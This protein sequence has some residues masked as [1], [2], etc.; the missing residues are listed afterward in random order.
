MMHLC[1]I[2][3]APLEIRFIDQHRQA[4]S[5]ARHIRIRQL[6]RVE[7]GADYALAGGGFLNLSDQGELPLPG[8]MFERAPEPAGLSRRRCHFCKLRFGYF[9]LALGDMRPL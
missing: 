5:T 7:I 4:V 6:Y 3:I 8:L 1:K 9:S 2:F